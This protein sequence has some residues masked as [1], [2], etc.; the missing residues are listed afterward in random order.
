MKP[1]SAA[2]AATFANRLS[3]SALQEPVKAGLDR[4]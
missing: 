3:G 2:E 1:E 4:H